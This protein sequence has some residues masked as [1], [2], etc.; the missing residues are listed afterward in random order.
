MGPEDRF[1]RLV[2]LV[3]PVIARR[4]FAGTDGGNEAITGRSTGGRRCTSARPARQHFDR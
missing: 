1:D 2:D 4:N 3:F